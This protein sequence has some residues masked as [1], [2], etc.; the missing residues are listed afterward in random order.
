M[1]IVVDDKI[2]KHLLIKYLQYVLF[3]KQN[4]L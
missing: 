4:V 1:K 3:F 2:I